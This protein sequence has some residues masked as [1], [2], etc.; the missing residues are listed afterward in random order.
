MILWLRAI[1]LALFTRDDESIPYRVTWSA[2]DEEIFRVG[3][4]TTA[5]QARGL[6]RR[7]APR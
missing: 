5:A 3:L 6:M 2:L 4:P 7:H 1:L